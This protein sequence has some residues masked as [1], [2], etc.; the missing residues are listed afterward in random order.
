M[1]LCHQQPHHYLQLYENL[2]LNLL[3][4]TMSPGTTPYG[5]I[6]VLVDGVEPPWEGLWFPCMTAMLNQL[7]GR[8]WDRTITFRFSVCC[9]HQ[10]YDPSKNVS[11]RSGP[12]T[13]RR[14]AESPSAMLGSMARLLHAH[15]RHLGH[16]I[17]ERLKRTFSSVSI[18]WN[19]YSNRD[20]NPEPTD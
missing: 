18:P 7:G 11:E 14:H 6:L 4:D 3:G 13:K 12:H 5:K 8:G 16:E 19:W 10:V 2:C 17:A 1:L 9:T 15:N 20:L